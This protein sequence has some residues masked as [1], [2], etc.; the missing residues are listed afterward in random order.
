MRR[1]Q[2]QG[3]RGL[4]RFISQRR[5]QSGIRRA[6]RAPV[7]APRCGRSDV[8]AAISPLLAREL[9][10]FGRLPLPFTTPV[11]F[12]ALCC[13]ARSSASAFCVLLCPSV[14]LPPLWRAPAHDSSV[15][16]H[17]VDLR[18]VLPIESGTR[19][20]RGLRDARAQLERGCLSS[21]RHAPVPRRRPPLEARS[22]LP[23]PSS[24]RGTLP[25]PGPAVSS[26]HAPV[27]RGRGVSPRSLL[28]QQRPLV[29]SPATAVPIPPRSRLARR[30]LEVLTEPL[31]RGRSRVTDRLT[32]RHFRSSSFSPLLSPPHTSFC[33]ATFPVCAARLV[34]LAASRPHTHTALSPHTRLPRDASRASRPHMSRCRRFPR[35]SVRPGSQLRRCPHRVPRDSDRCAPVPPRSGGPLPPAAPLV[36][37]ALR[38]FFQHCFRPGILP[39]STSSPASTRS[40]HLRRTPMPRPRAPQRRFVYISPLQRLPRAHS[41]VHR[42]IARH[43]NLSPSSSLSHTLLLNPSR[44]SGVSPRPFR[45]QRAPAVATFSTPFIPSAL[46]A[47]T[48]T[49]RHPRVLTL[50]LFFCLFF[51]G[52][53]GP[54]ST[55][56][57]RARPL[58]VFQAHLFFPPTWPFRPRSSSSASAPSRVVP[59][60]PLLPSIGRPDAFAHPFPVTRRSSTDASAVGRAPPPPLPRLVDSAERP[61]LLELFLSDRPRNSSRHHAT[62]LVCHLLSLFSS[63]MFLPRSGCLVFVLPL[64]LFPPKMG[65]TLSARSSS[66]LGRAATSVSFP[67]PPSSLHPL[68]HPRHLRAGSTLGSRPHR[69]PSLA[70]HASS[71]R[72]AFLPRLAARPPHDPPLRSASR[73]PSAALR[74]PCR[75]NAARQAPSNRRRAS[76]SAPSRALHVPSA[77]AGPFARPR[78]RTLPATGPPPL[79]TTSRDPL[80]SSPPCAFRS[81]FPLFSLFLFWSHFFPVSLF[82]SPS[83]FPSNPAWATTDLSDR[84]C[85]RA[86]PSGLPPREN[87]PRSSKSPFPPPPPPVLDLSRAE[88]FPCGERLRKRR[89]HP[90][91]SF[92][93]LAPPSFRPVPC[94]IARR[95]SF[96]IRALQMSRTGR[97]LP[98]FP[99]PSAR[100][101]GLSPRVASPT[102][103]RVSRR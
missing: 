89:P 5:H 41:R 91:R 95:F 61:P 94:T 18:Y 74:A 32:P 42:A 78:P 66:A 17:F 37:A 54:L 26:W 45:P 39:V 72:P 6:C 36:P 25:S 68:P 59:L 48:L 19:V 90:A 23:V 96:L 69:H 86:M 28:G 12:S 20:R 82:F 47:S 3:R 27:S 35:F 9:L 49:H 77:A 57:T 70:F 14:R 92:S 100:V 21:P 10:A 38:A 98:L 79:A 64:A 16:R 4:K 83:S 11:P 22:R 60:S 30:P 97:F 46:P 93:P 34:V 56:F 85:Q 58:A 43:R 52:A 53:R 7:R 71:P 44:L 13:L 75:G 87:E 67:L 50:C 65:P 62:A 31:F 33:A 51:F 81:P 73:A 103:Q 99:L 8:A 102:P 15:A 88:C 29:S 80:A 101:A 84:P 40:S 55:H 63:P 24:P 76:S 2:W 1:R